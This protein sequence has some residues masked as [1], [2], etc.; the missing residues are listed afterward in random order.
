VEELRTENDIL[1]RSLSTIQDN[2]D[3]DNEDNKENIMK[4]HNIKKK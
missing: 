3:D 4:D 2:N 1:K